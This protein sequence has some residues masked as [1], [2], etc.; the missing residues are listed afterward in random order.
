MAT[1]PLAY[2]LVAY[3]GTT[4]RKQFRWLPGG[5]TPQ[6]FTG[7]SGRLLIGRDY[8][9]PRIDTSVE[10]TDAGEINVVLT[11]EQTMT[12]AEG[13]WRYVIDLSDPAGDV[14]RFLRGRFEVVWDVKTS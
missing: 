11:P 1:L 4:F 7:W 3:S 6:N 2:E 9:E 13:I 8:N 14:T 12:L 5:T 10:L